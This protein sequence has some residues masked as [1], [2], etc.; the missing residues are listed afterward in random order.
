MQEKV[1]KNQIYFYA[2]VEGS[3]IWAFYKAHL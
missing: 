3:F 2:L 1:I